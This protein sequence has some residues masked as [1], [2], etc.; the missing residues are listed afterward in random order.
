M[1]VKGTFR[2]TSQWP[3]D[4]QR[5]RTR[6]SRSKP[7]LRNK[8]RQN[9]KTVTLEKNNKTVILKLKFYIKNLTYNF[10]CEYK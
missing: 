6:E 10:L 5:T 2:D 9:F 8:A 7:N 4:Q 1:R 3:R